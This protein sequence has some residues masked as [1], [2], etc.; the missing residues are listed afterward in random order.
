M[1]LLGT[2]PWEDFQKEAILRQVGDVVFLEPGSGGK[3]LERLVFEADVLFN[4]GP[5]Q[6]DPVLLSRSPT[7]KLVHVT[8]TGVDSFM[9]PEFQMS[10][11][12]LTNS[13]GVHAKVVAD[14]AMALLL[15]L[16][17]ALK[18]ASKNQEEKKWE[19][20]DICELEG[21]TA[22]LLGLGS[23]G[24]EIARRCKAF[25]MKV[26]GL[27]RE[28]APAENVDEVF[29]TSQ[30]SEVLRRSDFV[31]CSLPLTAET[32]HLL[33]F[34]EFS[35][36]KETAYFINVGRGPVVK[37]EDLVRALQEGRIRGAGLD[38]FEVEPLPQESPLWHMENVVITPHIAGV[39]RE[40]IQK[41]TDILAENLRRLARGQPLLNVVDKT[42]GY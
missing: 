29:P 31:L 10:P 19:R 26:V 17:H 9:V 16:T 23:I 11:I 8:A 33:T 3:S 21:K 34:R 7:L 20:M 13:R 38:V 42:R 5:A 28:S 30:L 41:S 14:H 25:S 37:E 36:M 35:A 22:G 24:L 18:R 32:R 1:R 27:R 4:Y 2:R 12:I 15:A 40:N 39:H 6:V